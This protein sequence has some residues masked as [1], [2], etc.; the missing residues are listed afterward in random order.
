[1]ARML[2]LHCSSCL[3]DRM[4][5]GADCRFLDNALCC[6]SGHFQMPELLQPLLLTS[7]VYAQLN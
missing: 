3:R 4:L 7:Y 1:M 2:L 5:L 6:W